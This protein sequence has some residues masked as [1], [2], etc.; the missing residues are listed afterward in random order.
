VG[1]LL[2]ELSGELGTIG[3]EQRLSWAATVEE[4]LQFEARR[5]CAALGDNKPTQQSDGDDAA[6]PPLTQLAIQA[7]DAL[8]LSTP[9]VRRPK[10]PTPP[11]VLSAVRRLQWQDSVASADVT[12]C[13]LLMLLQQAEF[14]DDVEAERQVRNTLTWLA[15]EQ[16]AS[17]Y[18]V[19]D[20]SGDAV[21]ALVATSQ[22]E[23]FFAYTFTPTVR[24][25]RRAE[26]V[27]AQLE[28]ELL[29]DGSPLRPDT[30]VLLD[31]LGSA[32]MAGLGIT[33]ETDAVL[34]VGVERLTIALDDRLRAGGD[35]LPELWTQLSVLGHIQAALG[36]ESALKPT[37]RLPC[38]GYRRVPHLHDDRARESAQRW[39]AGRELD[40][41]NSLTPIVTVVVPC[42]NLGLYV[43]EALESVCRQTLRDVSIIVVDDGSDDR[44]TKMT[45]EALQA[46]GVRV[47]SQSNAGLA[48]A[49]NRG[50]AEAVTPYVCCLDADD[51]IRPS[52]LE[53]IIDALQA[54]P[55]IAFA[56]SWVQMFGES[57]LTLCNMKPQLPD[58]LAFNQTVCTTVFRKTAWAS[59]GGFH[60][61][62]SIPGI[63]DWDFWLSLLE[64]GYRG[65]IVPE[66]L[67]E[68]RIR[69]NS[70]SDYMY[71]PERW[72]ELVRELIRRHGSLFRE[73]V[74]FV[75]GRLHSKWIEQRPWL[76]QRERAL[77]WWRTQAG[78]LE[79]ALTS[80]K[81]ALEQ[82]TAWV[83]ELE[84]TRA[85][86]ES[87]RQN[88]QRLAEE[89]GEQVLHLDAQLAHLEGLRPHSNDDSAQGQRPTLSEL[90]NACVSVA[91]SF[92][93]PASF[94]AALKSFRRAPSASRLLASVI[95][96]PAIAALPTF[97]R[98]A[99]ADGPRKRVCIATPDIVGP[100]RTG[101]IG[102]AYA[103]L[104]EALSSAGHVVTILYTRGGHCES[105]DL[106]E[107]V[108]HYATRGIEFVPL[109]ELDVPVD[110]PSE[111]GASYAAYSW[112]K[113]R[114]FDI[115][116]FPEMFGVGAFSAEAK[117][118]GL[119]FQK[120]TLCVGLHSPTIWHRLENRQRVE[121]IDDLILDA[122]ERKSVELA[123]VLVSPSRY[124]LDWIDGAGWR[125]PERTYIHPYA[126]ESLQHTR[127]P[128][129]I[130]NEVVFFGRLE[131]RKGLELFC[132]AI[133]L[134]VR[135][136]RSFVQQVTFLGKS[137]LA[138]GIDGAAYIASRVRRWPIRTATHA[139][140]SREEALDY[141]TRRPTLAV[142]PSL[143]DNTPNTVIECLRT[144]VPFISTGVGGIPEMIAE[145]D[146]S[147][148]L[149]EPEASTLAAAIRRAVTAG[150]APARPAVEPDDVRTRWVEWHRGLPADGAEPG[151]EPPATPLVSVCIATRNRPELL[152]Q[153]LA[154]IASQTYPR[155]EVVVV[156]DGGDSPSAVEAA[157]DASR[158]DGLSAP[159]RLLIEDRSFPG[160]ARNKAAGYARGQYI[161]FMDDDNLALPQEVSTLVTAAQHAQ[162]DIVTCGFS[163][164]QHIGGTTFE[165]Y[166]Q[167]LWLPI[168]PAM[169]LGLLMN[170]F[171]DTNMLIRR[172]AFFEVGGFDEE[173]GSGLSEDW[174]FHSRAFL[175]G[176]RAAAVPEA[177][178][179]Y[180]RWT[181]G[182][183]Q[184]G[185]RHLSYVRTLQPYLREFEPA[186]GLLLLYASGN[187]RSAA[188]QTEEASAET[189][190]AAEFESANP[191]ARLTQLDL[192]IHAQASWIDAEST[193][194]LR[195]DGN[196][197]QILMPRLS[198]K[199]SAPLFVRVDITPPRATMLQVFWIR[200]QDPNHYDE[201]RSAMVPLLGTRSTV[202]LKVPTGCLAA[203]LRLDPGF[204]KGTYVIHELEVRQAHAYEAS[205]VALDGNTVP[206]FSR[207]AV[208]RFLRRLRRRLLG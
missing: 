78:H 64:H 82:Q 24:N 127:Q 103:S 35:L 128:V 40:L 113:E 62:F 126:V 173:R 122:L 206:P 60:G 57:E 29:K 110:G 68:Y 121:S 162:M 39:L 137:G 155:L 179:E 90:V 75:V 81:G 115:V 185:S 161:L 63:E 34:A 174:I 112:L 129:G 169:P 93:D 120:T 100:V 55:E 69:I 18:L 177:L 142:M 49:R 77:H 191:V 140:K 171:G 41:P 208:R 59:V 76:A 22:I 53:K 4:G 204:V 139:D 91:E 72:D 111:W 92:P 98:S 31:L 195:A 96:R 28:R 156:D 36:D 56:G 144:N 117:R 164:F 87:Q 51:R 33:A 99:E 10:L 42:Y 2:L 85:W 146:R 7:I 84:S 23:P 25:T 54:Q 200:D 43:T 73:N 151:Q 32:K 97:D 202:V 141:L 187:F 143:S 38:A 83:D 61:G 104:A 116:H 194:A 52:F 1:V 27:L 21:K 163:A 94:E 67:F 198:L 50:T 71:S 138:G 158:R 165:R 106:D 17:C 152:A 154:S 46:R 9:A 95:P 184:S 181:G 16:G 196:D 132:D 150:H 133:E 30:V 109:S 160:A 70:M 188:D 178:F 176:M 145:V 114:T 167:F 74:E 14:G 6:N 131:S 124:L 147:R 183:G 12:R 189:S 5:L 123:D 199:N 125:R 130:P 3:V 180:R 58:I 190:T 48:A 45:L 192:K 15:D 47:I 197:P 102:S 182:A 65:T 170:C 44:L 8:A 175:A 193:I 148:V 107:W 86:L 26:A 13:L 20:R 135:E 119:A 153:A 79:D 205:P 108:E 149:V 186:F 66:L 19:P 172:E 134:L 88:W 37:R 207:A 157:I 166:P 201:D 118:L 203:P 168:G 101:G 11:D 89:R 136:D 159:I 105:G 80:A